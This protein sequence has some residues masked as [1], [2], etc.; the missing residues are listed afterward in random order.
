MSYEVYARICVG[1]PLLSEALPE[2]LDRFRASLGFAAGASHSVVL[3]RLREELPRHRRNESSRALYEQAFERF[4]DER[5]D[6]D[7]AIGG[8]S[9]GGVEPARGYVF[10]GVRVEG[11]EFTVRDAVPGLEA[12]P[13]WLRKGDLTIGSSFAAS[14]PSE[15]RKAFEH[16][17]RVYQRAG[18][19][20]Q[21]DARNR[22]RALPVSRQHE[23]TWA[24]VRWL[25][26]V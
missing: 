26:R 3:A 20:V 4:V 16:A 17:V 24:L 5:W 6:V 25:E 8:V 11:F 19:E 23:P 2:L 21:G 1:A 7:V 12:R 10:L 9:E 18:R 22:L 14:L 13:R 15:V